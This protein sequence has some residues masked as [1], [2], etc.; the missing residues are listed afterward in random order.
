LYQLP[1]A[2][3]DAL[4][5]Y[6]MGDFPVRIDAPAKV[7]LFAYDNGSLV[8]ES[9]RDE[10]VEVTVR[11][12]GSVSRLENLRTGAV[13]EGTMVEAQ[14]GRRSAQAPRSREEMEFK[15]TLPAHSYVALKEVE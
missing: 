5:S 12:K 14:G 7:S 4:R 2:E 13:V 10:A 8:V 1:E 6:V 11:V 3:L 9:F 15:V